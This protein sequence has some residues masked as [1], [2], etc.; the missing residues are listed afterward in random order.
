MTII[1]KSGEIEIYSKKG[2]V[3]RDLL[4]EG[5]SVLVENGAIVVDTVIKTGGEAITHGA[6]A[7]D[8]T[9]SSGG[10][11]DV[12]SG[13]TASNTY[14]S[15]GGL[16][17]V[18]SRALV[19]HTVIA[20]GS[21]TVTSATAKNTTISSGGF[22]I[23]SGGSITS[24]TTVLAGGTQTVSRGTT[25]GTA[26][27][28]GGQE[29]VAEYG[30]AIGTI[31]SQGGIMIE[32]TQSGVSGIHV[33]SGGSAVLA[34]GSFQGTVDSGG[35]LV[36]EQL[37]TSSFLQ[38]TYKNLQISKGATLTVQ[39]VGVTSNTAIRGGTEI[40]SGSG[41]ENGAQIYAGGKLI[42]VGES[43]SLGA[44]NVTISSGGEQFVSAGA[45]VGK[46]IVKNGGRESIGLSGTAFGTIVSFGG[47]AIVE[48]GVASSAIVDR[49][50]TLVV[51]S[52]GTAK[53]S[54]LLGGREEVLSGG[55][56]AGI[57]FGSGGQ[58]DI[59]TIGNVTFGAAGFGASNVIRLDG[60]AFG[61]TETLAYD[62]AKKV[63]TIT[64][65]DLKARIK[66]FGDYVAAGFHLA[67]DQAGGTGVT[68][69]V[70]AQA[71]TPALAPPSR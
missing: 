65:G 12:D 50:G 9:I 4:I 70:P 33:L 3:V 7:R 57:Y 42:V 26:V 32:H 47:T 46:T 68:Y 30:R 52:G 40:I 59:K 71:E 63:L 45:R 13:G 61:K 20:G 35:F 66:L 28:S 58:L 10:R 54:R 37:N 60:F 19:D 2:Q 23:L 16:Q 5:G 41:G 44:V 31:I 8:T 25:S 53:A 36:V 15:Q 69:T 11:Q 49:G 29:I 55:Q 27:R 38:A 21:Q 39:N 1:V 14:I 18:Y 48:G 24:Q 22:Q 62:A 64:D 56:F 34:G 67:R 17:Y 43:A 51:S 6:S